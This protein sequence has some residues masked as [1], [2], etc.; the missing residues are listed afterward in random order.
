MPPDFY[1]AAKKN[2][3]PG[4][5]ITPPKHAPSRVYDL[6]Y[7]SPLGQVL[8]LPLRLHVFIFCSLLL[9]L[10]VVVVS[11]PPPDSERRR[12]QRTRE[13][14]VEVR[15]RTHTHIGTDIEDVSFFV[16]KIKVRYSLKGIV[17]RSQASENNNNCY[18]LVFMRSLPPSLPLGCGVA[19][20]EGRKGRR[21][22]RMRS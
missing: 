18:S 20:R 6:F 5:R 9:L 7:A 16:F 15:K 21:R 4:G 22:R 12:R 8:P 10:R 3:C 17:H 19:L 13:D 1:G 14:F 2:T 11:G